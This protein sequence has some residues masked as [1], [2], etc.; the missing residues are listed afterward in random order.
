MI[1]PPSEFKTPVLP[2]GL[3]SIAAYLK[4]NNKDF[5]ISVIDAWAE[6][7]N[8]EELKKRIAQTNADFIGVSMV[9][10]R[11]NEA[12][13]TIKICRQ[14][15][16]EALIVA[17]GP[18]PSAVPEDTLKE[19]PELDAC[20]IGEGEITMHELA[21]GLEF[22]QID[23]IAFRENDQI[24]T[25]KP[26]EFIKDLD[27]LPYPARDIFPLEKYKTH[28]PY[29]RENPY[30]SMINSRGCPFN[31]A[32]CSKDVFKQTF[33]AN[34]PKRVCDELEMLIS[35]YNAKEIHFYDDDFTMDMQRAGQV[36][37]E[38]IKRK[39]KIRWSCTTR[40]NLVD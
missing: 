25:T 34:S 19:V 3:A 32:Y 9:S 40:V 26:R 21:A 13:E 33:R 2:L 6:R 14:I 35:R 10:P 30:F 29:G 37:D 27:L 11:Y 24:K 16:P 7:L 23:G 31:C 38:I 36:C 1:N 8:Y 17:G 22:S 5:D 18:H 4:Q 39:I 12:Q 20:V 28:P 15:F